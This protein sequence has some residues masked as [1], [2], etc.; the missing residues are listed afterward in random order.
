[1]LN[2]KT[3][4]FIRKKGKN[5]W[6]AKSL[7]EYGNWWAEGTSEEI[8]QERVSE[9]ANAWAL[10]GWLR[11]RHNHGL[12]SPWPHASGAEIKG[13]LYLAGIYSICYADT[14]HEETPAGSRHTAKV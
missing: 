8:R 3:Q 2:K 13:K 7:G 4:Y 6:S 12:C 11:S 14:V 9:A 5:A 10:S 1:M